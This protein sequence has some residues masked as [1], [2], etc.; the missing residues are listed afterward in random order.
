[1]WK[2]FKKNVVFFCL[3]QSSFL[4]HY[5]PLQDLSVFQESL[6]DTSPGSTNMQRECELQVLLEPQHQPLLLPTNEPNWRF[7]PL[8]HPWERHVYRDFQPPTPHAPTGAPP[9]ALRSASRLWPKLSYRPTWLLTPPAD[10]SPAFSAPNHTFT[11][12]ISTNSF[13]NTWLIL[14]SLTKGMS[15]DEDW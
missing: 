2:R 14:N 6:Q 12:P 5:C 9:T 3:L 13:S 1:M 4:I 15:H 11:S 8:R 7:S 10:D